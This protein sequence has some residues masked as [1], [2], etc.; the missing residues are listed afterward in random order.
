MLNDFDEIAKCLEEANKTANN[1]RH[2]TSNELQARF[3]RY[4]ATSKAAASI[5]NND[6]V[7]TINVI[8][9][10]D[11]L[12][13]VATYTTDK[14]SENVIPLQL[15]DTLDKYIRTLSDKE[16]EIY[17]KRYFYADPIEDIA[18]S[19]NMDTADVSLIL[20]KCNIALN[21]LLLN[22]GYIVKKETLF[23][24]FT[25]IGDD[26]IDM[27]VGASLVKGV[28]ADNAPRDNTSYSNDKET[29]HRTIVSYRKY[30]PIIAGILII[31]ALGIC[32]IFVL[33][34]ND[35]DEEAPTLP[36]MNAEFE[37]IFDRN[38]LYGD[39]VILEELLS[40]AFNNSTAIA[41]TYTTI[42]IT[43]FDLTYQS[44]GL[45]YSS[46]LPYCI[47]TRVEYLS[48][49][50]HTYYKL[51]GHDSM[52]YII[53]KQDDTYTLYDLYE[54]KMNASADTLKN[55]YA[56]GYGYI[57]SELYGIKDSNDIKEIRSLHY[58]HPT[59]IVGT[60]DIED[61]EIFFNIL[62]DMTFTDDNVWENVH[63]EIYEIDNYTNEATT[64]TIVT[65]RGLEFGLTYN[66]KDNFFWENTSG[67]IYNAI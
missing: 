1:V 42:S 3:V 23:T 67:I 65:E 29:K 12:E 47:G 34:D 17:V 41:P 60:A 15:S 11:E 48:D 38:D 18:K 10:L 40:Y 9:L 7:H 57:L 2:G 24:S 19:Y 66:Y 16:L 59:D 26:L 13:A 4:A 44:I 21:Q 51:L 52:Q 50:N 25:D 35:P 30:I 28:L 46:M 8:S 56:Y 36:E 5:H 64:L 61:I 55:T 53:A 45:R 20:Q 49:D 43:G 58:S 39:S 62:S 32:L 54:L 22:N 27:H 31:L 33:G 6:S 63:N 37:P 14:K